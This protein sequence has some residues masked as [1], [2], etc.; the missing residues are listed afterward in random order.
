MSQGLANNDIIQ[1]VLGNI[2]LI[3]GSSSIEMRKYSK[4]INFK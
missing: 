1:I 4:N 2:R 3:F